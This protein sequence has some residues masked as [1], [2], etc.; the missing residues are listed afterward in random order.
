M[1]WRKGKPIDIDYARLN[2]LMRENGM[3][4]LREGNEDKFVVAVS[5][6]GR[7]TLN[8]CGRLIYERHR[9]DGGRDSNPFYNFI[10]DFLKGR[11][12]RSMKELEAM[13]GPRHFTQRT[14]AGSDF[15][16]DYDREVGIE[17]QTTLT[18]DAKRQEAERHGRPYGRGK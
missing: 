7:P 10:I 16:E 6:E 18:E 9:D 1:K 8:I 3:K 12:Q 13:R 5:S 4:I 15:Q 11:A 14:G 2:K 17:H